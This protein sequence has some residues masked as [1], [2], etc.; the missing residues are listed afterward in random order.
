MPKRKTTRGGKVQLYNARGEGFFGD[1]WSGI[2][3]GFNFIKDNKIV[4][5]VASLIPHP[6]AQG[7]AQG[8]KLFGMGHGKGKKKKGGTGVGK[9][10]I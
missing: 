10:T 8:A 9:I 5:G 3:K 2:K 6:A 7:I 1:L 4:S